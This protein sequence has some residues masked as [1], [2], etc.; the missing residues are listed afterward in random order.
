MAKK[1]KKVN[2]TKEALV[3]GATLQEDQK[4]SKEDELLSDILSKYK[5]SCSWFDSNK[6]AEYDY[7]ENAS[8]SH[9]SD[10]SNWTTISTIF[11]PAT[12][13]A[14]RAIQAKTL[15]T[16]FSN[17]KDFFDLKG[18]AKDDFQKAKTIKALTQTVFNNMPNFIEQFATFNRQRVVYGTAVGKVIWDTKTTRI[19]G[20]EFTDGK[21]EIVEK[22]VVTYKGPRF[23]AID[24]KEAFRIDPNATGIDGFYKFHVTYP[25]L[26]SVKFSAESMGYK[27]IDKITQSVTFQYNQNQRYVSLEQ[28]PPKGEDVVELIEYW[29]ADNSRVITI[30][31]RCVILKDEP[32]PFFHGKHPFVNAVYEKIDF[33][34]YGRG[35][36]MKVKPQQTWLNMLINLYNDNALQNINGMYDVPED[37]PLDQIK[38]KP[39]GCVKGGGQIKPLEKAFISGD[40]KELIA[41]LRVEIEEVSGATRLTTAVGNMVQSGSA[42][43]YLGTKATLNEG[44]LTDT[45][46]LEEMG[47]INIVRMVYQLLL[48]CMDEPMF[49]RITNEEGFMVKP[50]DIALNVDFEPKLGR[51]ILSKSEVVSNL[52]MFLQTVGPVAMQMGI[53]M[54]EIMSV[55]AKAMGI[56]QDLKFGAPQNMEPSANP[57]TPNMINNPLAGGG[58]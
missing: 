6:R 19:K 32:N 10:K 2:D 16:V 50:E 42:T 39:Q 47:I 51:Q 54:K 33:K 26:S 48:Q 4:P 44:H 41:G 8:V 13:K 18:V 30:A 40:S 12:E 25:T 35:I 49:V 28:K 15:V 56:D 58:A 24:M 21:Y 45:I 36:P 29:S 23:L 31:N 55:L 53:D 57:A 11:D 43:Q 3:T 34:F 46:M 7:C 22:D 38:F 27:N 5:A 37:F 52:V 17:G 20:R 1:S 14:I 9:L